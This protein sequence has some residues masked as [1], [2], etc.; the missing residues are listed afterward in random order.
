MPGPQSRKAALDEYFTVGDGPAMV[1]DVVADLMLWPRAHDFELLMSCEIDNFAPQFYS[2]GGRFGGVVY[3]GAG[4]LGDS[5]G[6][7]RGY[8]GGTWSF[9]LCYEGD[10]INGAIASLTI[11][12]VE[13]ATINTTIGGAQSVARVTG[14]SVDQGVHIFEIVSKTG[15]AGNYL[16]LRHAKAWRTGA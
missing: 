5:M 16:S 13:V 7:E 12:D 9:E 10:A 8:E 3:N 1:T 11:D 4:A 6:W 15:G 14:V 2:A